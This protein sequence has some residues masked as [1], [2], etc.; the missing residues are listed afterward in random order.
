[1]RALLLPGPLT[2]RL[3]A[4][5]AGKR[6]SLVDLAERPLRDLGTAGESLTLD[7]ATGGSIVTVR[8]E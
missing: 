2:L 5:L 7:A 6:A 3:P 1:M 4:S 8:L